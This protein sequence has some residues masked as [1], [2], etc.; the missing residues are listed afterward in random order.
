MQ[1]YKG[2]GGEG[3]ILISE[4]RDVATSLLV[5]FGMNQKGPAGASR[6]REPP[7]HRHWRYLVTSLLHVKHLE[8]CLVHFRRSESARWYYYLLSLML[9]LILFC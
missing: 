8:E 9:L 4:G 1:C 3:E 7:L 2:G 5:C 6:E